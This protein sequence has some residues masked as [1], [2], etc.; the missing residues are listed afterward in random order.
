MTPIYNDVYLFCMGRGGGNAIL[1]W[2]QGEFEDMDGFMIK[3]GMPRYFS[4]EH[5]QNIKK[6]G[7]F[8]ARQNMLQGK[9]LGCL[10]EFEKEAKKNPWANTY[11]RRVILYSLRDP[12]NMLASWLKNW[13]KV[14]KGTKRER[15]DYLYRQIIPEWKALAR[16]ALKETSILPDSSVFVSYNQWFSDVNYRKDL[17]FKLGL[18]L[19]DKKINYVSRRGGGSSFSGHRKK[20]G[21][22]LDVLNRWSFYKNNKAYMRLFDPELRELSRELF[23]F[24][25]L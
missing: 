21:T 22:K 19:K 17:V 23:N 6:G 13:E 10:G 14:E 2:L 20:R 1:Y 5:F 8:L 25:P 11:G 24:D 16:E 9:E 7:Y 3:R 12:F 18:S 15:N 4:E